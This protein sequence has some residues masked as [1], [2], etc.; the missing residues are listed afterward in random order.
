MNVK[1][2]NKYRETLKWEG[3]KITWKSIPKYIWRTMKRNHLNTFFLPLDW[4][5]D[6]LIGPIHWIWYGNVVFFS[7]LWCAVQLR[8]DFFLFSFPVMWLLELKT[9][10]NWRWNA[11]KYCVMCK[12]R[13][14]PYALCLV[15]S[16]AAEMDFPLVYTF[17]CFGFR[18]NRIF[19]VNAVHLH[20]SVFLSAGGLR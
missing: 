20:G 11:Y 14:K 7:L 17:F 16:L 9:N 12:L 8:K 4:L 2:V 1:I 10:T 13:F 5:N 6:W 19:I 18:F 3:E 15:I